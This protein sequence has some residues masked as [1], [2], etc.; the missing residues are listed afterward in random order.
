MIIT[1]ILNL[2]A[3]IGAITLHEAAHGIVAYLFKDNTAKLYGRLT[4]NPIKH[5]DLVGTV[6]L[7]GILYLSGSKF[8][9]GWAKPVP[10][11]FSRLTKVGIICV[12]V[13]GPFMNFFLAWCAA[14]LLHIN[15][16]ASTLGNDLLIQFL[17]INAM[18]GVFNMLPIPPLD[19]GRVLVEILPKSLG[20]SLSKIEPFTP[21]IFLSFMMFP[22]LSE[23]FSSLIFPLYRFILNI[24]FV[25]SGHL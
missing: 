2:V 10:V 11:D 14:I 17:K 25:L 24:I 6:I 8:L 23:V 20:S 19:G 18:L 3:L 22:M 12:S 16:G 15:P 21:L 9:L 1:T 7:P 5:M 13:S 4:L